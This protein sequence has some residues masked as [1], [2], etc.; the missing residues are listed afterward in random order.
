MKR[1]YETKVTP[2]MLETDF[3]QRNKR[4]MLKTLFY[5]ATGLMCVIAFYY[6]Q[7]WFG[8]N[9][10]F[11]LVL[12][13]VLGLLTTYSVITMQS[14]LDLVTSIEFQNALFSSAFREGKLFSL[15]VSNDEQMY[16][17]DADF[18]KLYPALAKGNGQILDQ[19]IQ[20]SDDPIDNNAMLQNALL[21]R[22]QATF[23]IYVN[24][25]QSRVKA[26]LT[27]TPLQR[28]RGYFYV[29][30]RRYVEHRSS[31][32]EPLHQEPRPQELEAVLDMLV[33]QAEDAIYILNSNGQIMTA[34]P[35]FLALLET[36]LTDIAGSFVTN[37][38]F[39]PPQKDASA[40]ASTTFEGQKL[41]FRKKSGD[42]LLAEVTHTPVG[43]SGQQV[44]MTVGKVVV[45]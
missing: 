12:V 32:D 15:I 34:S 29:S 39:N 4:S 5:Y 3:T 27:M 17:A 30:A 37:H 35:A 18:C 38:L 1:Y 10:P 11:V 16:Y 8:L 40:L 19:L 31:R 21:R 23:D 14:H 41:S 20:D 7:G 2:D 44:W 33:T 45:R 22:E 24:H 13:L 36:S 26:R 25:E 42:I 43:G 9:I 28:P 6:T